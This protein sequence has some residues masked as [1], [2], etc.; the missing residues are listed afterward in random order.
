[1]N[2]VSCQLRIKKILDEISGVKSQYGVTDWEFQRLTEWQGFWK[3]SDKQDRI[4][5]AV[6]KK[7]FDQ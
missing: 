7:V 5:T 1:M 6:E 4:V 3:L 2:E